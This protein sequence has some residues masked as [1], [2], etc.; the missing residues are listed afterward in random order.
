MART[1]HVRSRRL[2][3]GRCLHEGGARRSLARAGAGPASLSRVSGPEHAMS[4]AGW[5]VQEK[6]DETTSSPKPRPNHQTPRPINLPK[7][8]AITTTNEGHP[9]QNHNTKF[10]EFVSSG[11]ASRSLPCPCR[12][13][14]HVRV[15]WAS[16]VCSS[17]W[18][19]QL[20]PQIV[21]SGFFFVLDAGVRWFAGEVVSLITDS[22]PLTEL[23]LWIQNPSG[24]LILSV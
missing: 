14:L 23:V 13:E 7:T 22:S 17:L 4:Q 18:L 9:S 3:D 6:T 16:S 15:V 8:M 10:P 20:A 12:L 2:L 21:G 1:G 5:A 19:R 11:F 24:M